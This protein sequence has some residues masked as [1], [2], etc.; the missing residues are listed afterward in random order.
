MYTLLTNSYGGGRTS[1]DIVSYINA[2]AGTN[3]KVIIPPTAVTVLTPAN[4]DAVAYDTS[5]HVLVE[6]YA[7]WYVRLLPQG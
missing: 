3:A 6:F 7:P 5:K 1:N 2:Q 4:F